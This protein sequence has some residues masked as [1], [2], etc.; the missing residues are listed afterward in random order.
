LEQW[1]DEQV[2]ALL[3][4]VHPGR[5]AQLLANTSGRRL[6]ALAWT[7]PGDQFDKLVAVMPARQA[8]QVMTWTHPWL[9]WAILQGPLNETKQA[10]YEKLPP[11]RR[12]AWRTWAMALMEALHERRTKDQSYFQ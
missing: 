12:W 6:R 9:T 3:A 7:M 10:L 11:I 5:G 4:M 1:P 2:Q 8:R